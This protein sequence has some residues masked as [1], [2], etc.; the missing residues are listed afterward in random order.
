MGEDP[1]EVEQRIE[2][3]RERMGETVDALSAKADVPGRMKGY[4]EE[5]KEAV[6]SKITGARERVSDDGGQLAGQARKGA[7]IA[8]E[9]P[10]GLAIGSVA[11][12]FLIGMLL[13]ESRVEN[14]RLGPIAGQVKDQARDVGSEAVAHGKQIAQDAAQAATDTAKQSGQQHASDFQETVRDSTREAA[15]QVRS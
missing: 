12:G 8:K 11:A 6:T 9:N 2:D 3:T 7:G 13:P 5:K 10:L 14:E 15:Q 1:R 4:V